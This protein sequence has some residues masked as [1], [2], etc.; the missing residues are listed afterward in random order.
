MIERQRLEFMYVY[1][2]N[3]M[4]D[5]KMY[6]RSIGPYSTITQQP[7]KGKFHKGGQML[8]EMEVWLL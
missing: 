2:L 5:D 4:V 8:G 3:H 1:K 7:L 6:A